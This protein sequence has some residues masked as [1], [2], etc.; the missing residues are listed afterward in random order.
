MKR[1]KGLKMK[2]LRSK[3]ERIGREGGKKLDETQGELFE[4]KSIFLI[5]TPFSALMDLDLEG[6]WDPDSHDRQMTSLYGNDED[7]ADDKPQWEDDIDIGDIVLDEEE[8]ESST[9]KKKKAKKKKEKEPVEEEDGVDVDEMDADVA[10]AE[11][12][13]EEWDGTEE[14]RKRKLDEYMD[15][16]Y[17]LD[18]NDMVSRDPMSNIHFLLIT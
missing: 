13:E 1:L 5:L 16:I 10:R 4:R 2:E 9:K 6:D 8:P 18:F 11:D 3:L 14:M 15:E 12:D 17:G 7:F